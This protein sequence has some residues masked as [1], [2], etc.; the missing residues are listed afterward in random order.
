VVS[1]VLVGA[2]YGLKDWLAQ[3]VTAVAMLAYTL[4]LPFALGRGPL[5][6][7]SWKAVFTQGWMRAATFVF[8]ASV[9]IHAWI[10]MRNI[11]MDYVHH[12]GL[13]LALQ[14]ATILWL[15]ACA[16]WA[17]QILWRI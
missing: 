1:R 13:R 7:A 8:V 2:H 17:M 11:F 12:T 10:G 4:M 6:Y 3:R 16:G 9:L 5:T 15:V 14:I